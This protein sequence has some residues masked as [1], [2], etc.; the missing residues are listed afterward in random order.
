MKKLR[1]IMF[2][3]LLLGVLTTACFKDNSMLDL[4]KITAVTL[5][6]TGFG[7]LSV[8]QFEKLNLIPNLNHQGL[9]ESDLSHEWKIN[10][11]PNDTLYQVVGHEKELDFLVNFKPNLSGRFHQ[12]VYTVTENTSDLD[13]IFTWPVK[14]LNNIGEGLVIAQTQD[15]TTTDISHIMSSSVTTDYAELSIKH[16]VYSSINGMTMPGI[17]K[18]MRYAK[19]AGVDIVFGITD[20]NIYRINT[21]DYTFSGSNGDLFYANRDNYQFRSIGG[22]YQGDLFI[23]N[24]KLTS[25]FLG[26]SRKIG[27]PF[28]ASFTV[29]GIVASN[30][31]SNPAV[32]ISFYDEENEQFVYQPSITPFGDNTMYAT[33]NQA[34]GAFDPSAQLNRENLAAGVSTSGDFMHLLRNKST[35]AVDL[36]LFDKGVSAYPT[37]EPPTAIGHFNLSNAPNIDKAQHFAFLDNQ[38]VLYYATTTTIYAILYGTATATIEER[39][40][41]PAGETITTLQVYQQADYPLRSSG[42]YLPTNNK[43]LVMSTYDGTTGKVY[44][45]PFI[46]TGIGNIDTPKIETYSGFDRI[47]AITAQL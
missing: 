38:K 17:T 23:S 46:N 27:L 22:V 37:P 34:S 15:G 45:L 25:T 14:V 13:Y 10:L 19:M 18:Q 43:S 21:L 11:T 9:S 29:P 47:T 42:N 39:F 20:E 31:L 35:G 16:N 7:T 5:D 36:Y 8:Y 3:P 1:Y 24:G 28:N 32:V 26:A 33:P 40:V 6:T 41:V 12:L 30:K 2:L 4:N 44:L